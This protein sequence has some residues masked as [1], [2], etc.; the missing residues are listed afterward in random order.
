[1][2]KR[3]NTRYLSVNIY[4]RVWN[5]TSTCFIADKSEKNKTYNEFELPLGSFEQQQ[6]QSTINIQIDEPLQ[7]SLSKSEN[8]EITMPSNIIGAREFTYKF[9]SLPF[10]EI[11]SIGATL[12]LFKDEDECVAEV[13]LV[14]RFCERAQDRDMLDKLIKVVITKYNKQEGV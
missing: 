1:M 2:N 10:H 3:N 9:L 11:A 7:Y 14:K 12:G 5:D 8:V 6:S 4:S 13:E